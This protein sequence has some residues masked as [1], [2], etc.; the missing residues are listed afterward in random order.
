MIN[1]SVALSL[2]AMSLLI[3]TG[4][5]YA[6][7]TSA[8]TGTVALGAGTLTLE[9]TSLSISSGP[10]YA[11]ITGITPSL[12]A[13]GTV[14]FDVGP[15]APGDTIVISYTVENT[16]TLPATSIVPTGFSMVSQSCDN[17]FFLSS[18]GLTPGTLAAGDSF[19]STIGVTLNAATPSNDQGCTAIFSFTLTG[20]IGS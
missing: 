5:G 16:G 7:F 8:V 14:S 10:S 2:L 3:S 9:F 1:R 17:V 6:A 11:H 13:T 4:V 15:V 12:P 20:S 19:S 18:A